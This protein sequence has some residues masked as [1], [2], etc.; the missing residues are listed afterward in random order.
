[1]FDISWRRVQQLAEMYRS[2]GELP[3]QRLGRL[4]LVNCPT[5]RTCTLKVS[6]WRLSIAQ[7]FQPV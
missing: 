5:Q 2:T 7:V 3:L 4:V 6:T 1:M